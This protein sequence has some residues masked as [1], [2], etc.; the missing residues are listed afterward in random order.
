MV[1]VRR[2]SRLLAQ[3]QHTM[4]CTVLYCTHAPML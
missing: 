4:Y 1:R 3:Y 2:P